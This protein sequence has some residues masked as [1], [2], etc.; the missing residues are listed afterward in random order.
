[1]HTVHKKN[2]SVPVS[3]SSHGQCGACVEKWDWSGVMQC[4]NHADR[5]TKQSQGS[6]LCTSQG[7]R[8]NR[9]SGSY[10]GRSGNLKVAGPNLDLAVLKPSLS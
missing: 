9:S 10:S 2:M 3:A 8:M 6:V 1:M 7:G 4:V 5:P